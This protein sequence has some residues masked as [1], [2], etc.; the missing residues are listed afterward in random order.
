MDETGTDIDTFIAA[1][2]ENY[3]PSC[4]ASS[5]EESLDALAGCIDGLSDSDL[6]QS[7]GHRNRHQIFVR[8]NWI[9]RGS[10]G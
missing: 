2:H 10:N 5:N 3:L 1:L 9:S 7:N 6:L 4:E 8:K